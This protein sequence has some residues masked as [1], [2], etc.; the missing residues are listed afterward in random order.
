MTFG[1]K[2]GICFG[3]SFALAIALGLSSF[4][5]LAR[6]HSAMNQAVLR[7]SEKASRINDIRMNILGFRFAERGILLFTEAHGEAK[8]EA[9]KQA[10][11][12]GIA[13]V[14]AKN[15]ELRPM[16]ET[17]RGR[18]LVD[19][20]DAD[21]AEYKRV[22]AQIPVLCASGKVA[23]AMQIDM[24]QLVAIGGR[25]T[26][27]SEELLT[28]QAAL[29][30]E[31][32]AGAGE[33]LARAKATI[34]IVLFAYALV[35]ALA[36]VVTIRGTKLLRGLSAQ[37]LRSS[38]QI[39]QIA[40]QVTSASE[41]LAS[42]ASAQA[43]SIEETSA[44]ATEVAAMAGENTSA[45]RSAERLLEEAD[46]IGEKNAAAVMQMTETITRIDASTSG[47]ARVIRVI[48]EIAFQTNILALNAAVEAARAGEAGMGFAVVADE[49]R[50]LAQ[51]SATAARETA[52]MIEQS[53]ASAR[54]G[55][56]RI[57][58]V[59]DSFREAVRVRTAVKEHTRQI[60]TSG[61]EQAH[62]IEQI[63]HAVQ[64]MT[65]LAENTA[66]QAQQGTQ[67]G[68]E[69]SGQSETLRGLVEE[70]ERT[71]GRS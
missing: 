42:G 36:G 38:G 31:A 62:G 22:Q 47:I 32:M 46:Q 65:H 16:L 48:D 28:R 40:A 29:N 56:E 41:S 24:Q 30:A 59:G 18:Q 67:A 17:D 13:I 50:S 14:A 51:R 1:R 64:Q 10:F 54:E 55:T 4:L 45:A 6:L 33:L 27:A 3:A 43:A 21:V 39:G 70:L 23:E 25:A 58:A 66:A 34:F 8:V 53:I 9:N 19:Q 68:R 69:L 44:S 20:I 7:G 26:A 37:F 2:V 49:V 11:A 15:Q 57:A 5:Y 35:A 71:M 61:T 63:A 52:G 12:K 60:A